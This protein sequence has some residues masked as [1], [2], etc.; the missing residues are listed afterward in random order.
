MNRLIIN[1][2]QHYCLIFKSLILI[3]I[4]PIGCDAFDWG[5]FHIFAVIFFSFL[6][7][8][9]GLGAIFT[10]IYFACGKRFLNSFQKE[11]YLS[12]HYNNI[13]GGSNT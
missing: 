13:L 3:G 11:V 1:F 9:L 8:F 6:G 4:L 7:G 2:K 10:V 5:D 12:K